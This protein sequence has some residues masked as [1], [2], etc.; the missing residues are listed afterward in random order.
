MHRAQPQTTVFNTAR[1]VRVKPHEPEPEF[2]AGVYRG[3]KLTCLSGEF[4]RY[5]RAVDAYWN[6]R[7]AEDLQSALAD[8]WLQRQNPR[9]WTET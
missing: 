6:R 8:E 5:R 2:F 1:N 4:P 3:F 9:E 7:F